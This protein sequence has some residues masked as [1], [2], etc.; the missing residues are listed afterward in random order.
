[1]L[2]KETFGDSL[3]LANYFLAGF[4]VFIYLPIVLLAMLYSNILFKLRS[5]VHLGEHSTNAEE[6]RTRRNE[7]VLK[8]AIAIVLGFAICWVPFTVTLLLLMFAWNFS[9]PCSA[10]DYVTFTMFLAYTNCVINPLICFTFSSNYRQGLKR[11][12]HCFSSAA[13]FPA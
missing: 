12:I 3:S 5:Q 6:Q 11:L 2:W 4:I 13:V 10:V 1:M 7:S 9:V 8:M